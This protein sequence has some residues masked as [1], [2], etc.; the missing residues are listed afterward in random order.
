MPDQ[1][2]VEPAQPRPAQPEPVLP[3][4]EIRKLELERYKARLDYRKFV[5]ASVFAA[6]TI[7]AIPPLF[8]LATALLEYT[9]SQAQLRIDQQ[10][11]E[12]ERLAKQE[13][14]RETYVK[15]FLAN[16]LN[17]D[18]ELRIRFSE[19]FAFVSAESFR[20]GWTQ[21]HD[22]LLKHRDEIREQIS[23]LEDEW[24]RLKESPA[25]DNIRVD[26]VT[27][28][29]TW[30][31]NE[32]GYVER[33]RSVTVNPRAPISR[34]IP[35]G[36]QLHLLMIGIG[37]Y[38]EDYAKTLRD[39]YAKQDAADLATSL[40]STQGKVYSQIL[41]IFLGDRDASKGG[42]LRALEAIRRNMARSTGNDLAI[43]YLAG[44]A[45]QIDGRLYLLP[46]D[47]DA[48][49]EAGIKATAITFDDLRQEL[50][51][52]TNFGQVLVLVDTTQPA[53]INIDSLRSELSGT[54]ISVFTATRGNEAA[55]AKE[56]WHHGAFA[57]AFMDALSDPNADA[58]RTGIITTLGLAQYLV[59]RIPT[60]TGGMQNPGVEIRFDRPLFAISQPSSSSISR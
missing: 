38:N 45:A 41:P 23:Q 59:A 44:C 26:Y 27:R 55:V 56:E 18:I 37:T 34:G 50:I 2:E 21:Y 36:A 25:P 47:V 53:Q 10:N 17:Q 9:K 15:D 57:K 22:T 8:Q 11:R 12:A 54:N 42:I 14:F 16:A 60:L 46:Y 24:R 33:N 6:I 48:R 49:D 31:Y 40:L 4:L 1:S 5:L 52:L 39:M 51:N 43:I 28:T 58:D 30:L 35:S 20:K 13:E 32:V 7:A 29:L 3:E 19:Y